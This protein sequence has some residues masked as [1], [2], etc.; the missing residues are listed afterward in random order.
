MSAL[1]ACSVAPF[2][3]VRNGAR[4]V[5]FYKTAFGAIEVFRIEAPDGA[6]VSRLSVDGAEFWLSDESPEHGNFSP[7]SLGGGSVRMVLTVPDPDAM[8]AKAIAAGALEVVAVNDDYG[9][10]LGRVVDPFGHHWEIGR[11]LS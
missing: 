3:S 8:F 11:P 1:I 2:L 5:E 4:A 6:V 7:E 10:R 9:W